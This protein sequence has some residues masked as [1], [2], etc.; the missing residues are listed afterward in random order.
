M[1]DSPN[2]L[3]EDGFV[4]GVPDNSGSLQKIVWIS[5]NQGMLG[6]GIG[7]KKRERSLPLMIHPPQVRC[8]FN[9]HSIPISHLFLRLNLGILHYYTEVH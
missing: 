7:G 6:E 2:T 8:N 1:V 4:T 5:N 3:E 9:G